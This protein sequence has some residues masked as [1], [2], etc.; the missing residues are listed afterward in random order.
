MNKLNRLSQASSPYLRQHAENPVDW[1]EWGDEA[2]SKAK[3]E[4]KPLI[5]SVGYAACHW[6]HVMAR[7]SFS[8]EA[9]ADFMN[10]HFV[11]IKID[12]EE[13]PDIDQIYM[14]AAH[15][16]GGQSGW[17]LNAFAMPD[18]KPFFTSTYLPPD[19]WLDALNQINGVYN[20]DPSMIL[21]VAESLTEGLNAHPVTQLADSTSFTTNEYHVA[22]QHH[23]ELIDFKEGGYSGSPKFV[24]P[25][26]LEFFLQYYS[27]TNEHK[28][29]DAVTLT[30]DAIA[31]GGIYDQI[32]GG[33]ARYST[34]PFW[35]VPHFEK[36]LY[37]NSQLISLYA[38]AFQLTNK[39][40]Y[41]EI[42]EGIISFAERELLNK[43]GGFYA[44]IDADSEHEEGKFY[45]WTKQEIESV[46]DPQH[47]E[48]IIQ[49]YQIFR[50]GNWESE[51]NIL[52]SDLNKASFAKRNGL[53]PEEFDALLHNANALLLK[54]R[55]SRIR[56]TTDD[57]IL[58]S[59]NALMISAYVN[60]YKALGK[61]SY[62]QGA[63]RTAQFV[64]LN[65]LNENG[66]LY[67]VFKEG[68]VSIDAFLDDYALLA[69]ACIGLYEIT[70]DLHWLTRSQQLISYVMTHFDNSENNLFYYTSD[71][72]ENLIA[73]KQDI[74]DNVI[75]SSNSILAN[76]FY[77]LGV[78][79]ENSDYT[80]TAEKMLLNVRNE[81]KQYGSYFANWAVL[82]GKF[83]HPVFELAILGEDALTFALE[84]Q[85]NH[86]PTVIFAGGN[87]E[88]L[89]LF[90]QRLIAGKTLIYV[91][92]NKVCN[93]PVESVEE[94]LLL[95]KK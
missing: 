77:K 91:C 55:N 41:A 28:A 73:R 50:K 33:F 67:R 17:P 21:E 49:F 51:K 4:N 83:T 95:L 18:G 7:E 35:K 72:A 52:H 24:L 61:E 23:I 5:I 13:R 26:S 43:T 15:L 66:L 46:I 29:L 82:L 92:K 44:S 36:M 85:K 9:I 40:L 32:G 25:A 90:K 94:A 65:M 75:P 53:A 47:A 71:Q 2:L 64:E 19:H 39:P 80:Q 3:L 70:F 62:L 88:N 74:S 93:L 10:T 59:W 11:C 69:E 34:D 86:L 16:L 31:K 54:H 8:D 30:L 38:H 60:A 57:K 76:V 22:Y 84:M 42:I 68:K 78:L 45:V 48:L 12:R 14:E 27:L 58:T 6:C 56:P 20:A 63:I 1:F 81:I 79:F 89:P 87:E 37:D